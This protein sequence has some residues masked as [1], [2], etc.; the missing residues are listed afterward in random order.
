M[1]RLLYLATLLPI[2]GSGNFADD[3][4]NICCKGSYLASLRN[5]CYLIA[6]LEDIRKDLT[7][8]INEENYNKEQCD[9]YSTSWYYHVGRAQAFF[10]VLEKVEILILERE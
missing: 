10:E 7:F 3:T 9:L 1:K 6:D 2:I 4:S 8:F 5:K